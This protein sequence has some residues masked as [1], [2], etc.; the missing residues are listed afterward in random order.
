MICGVGRRH[1][2]G[3]AL[4]WLWCRPEASAP[5]GP[6]AWEP[7]YAAEVA[8]EKEK[9]KKKKK[10]DLWFPKRIGDR[11]GKDWEFGI[12]KLL[13]IGWINNW[14]GIGNY[15]Q[16]SVINHNGKEYK[17]NICILNRFAIHRKLM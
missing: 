15:I 8:L 12:P 11:G 16:Y 3:L 14:Y 1:G 5:T 6:L 2:S 4:L 10:T 13:C 17:N 9:K 7:P